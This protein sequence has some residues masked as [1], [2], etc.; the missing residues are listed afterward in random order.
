MPDPGREFL[1]GHLLLDSGQLRG[2]FFQRTV[3]LI[4]QHDSEGAFGLVLNKPTGSIVGDVLLSDVP[5]SLKSLPVFSGG[6]LQPTALS[7]L[8][9]SGS[10][11][12]EE[13]VIPG[14]TIGH[15]LEFLRDF[16]GQ[17]PDPGQIRLFAGYSGWSPGQLESEIK[18]EA[19]LTHPA[20]FDLIFQAQ[21]DQLWQHV[22]RL[23]G[24][25]YRIL[26]QMPEEPELN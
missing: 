14:V 19:W 25:Q 1:N 23:K 10:S 15:S 26:S 9:E 11:D 4:C 22:L 2:S 3:V 24:W 18:R 17:E 5:D 7:Y 13:P 8:R 12:H 6:P 21:P 16:A 20:S